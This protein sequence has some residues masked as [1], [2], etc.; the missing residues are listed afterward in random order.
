M[1]LRNRVLIFLLVAIGISAVRIGAEDASA[2]K[3]IVHPSNPAAQMTRLKV[4]EFFLKKATRWPDALPVMPVEPSG[5]SPVRQRFTLEVYGKQV[6]AISAYWQQMIFS[7]K[8]V[9]PPEK[10]ND[11]DVVAFVRDTPGAIGYVWAGADVSGVKVVA[12]TD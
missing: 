1:N 7:G 8:G 3:L 5:K 10:S 2:Y 4:G 9:P 6:I 11:A 12:V